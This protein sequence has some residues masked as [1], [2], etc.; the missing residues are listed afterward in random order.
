MNFLRTAHPQ[1]NQVINEFEIEE[2]SFSKLHRLI[3]LVESIIKTHTAFIAS[4]Y[5]KMHL[6][7]DS[8]KGLLAEGLIT[9]SLGMWQ[10]VSRALMEDLIV[11]NRL[12]RWEFKIIESCLDENQCNI[13]NN[14]YE[15]INDSY[16]LKD[17]I[18]K[19]EKDQLLKY[20]GRTNYQM[21][22]PLFVSGFYAYFKEWDKKIKKTIKTKDGRELKDLV[23]FRNHYA[24][25]AT[26]SAEECERAI[27]DYLPIVSN[28]LQETWLQSISVLVFEKIDGRLQLVSFD[29]HSNNIQIELLQT[30]LSTNKLIK[31]DIP[32]FLNQE[33]HLLD[34]SPLLFYKR[35]EKDN[36][37][38]LLFLNDLKRMH[39]EEIS[40]LNYPNAFHFQDKERYKQF[41]SIINIPEWKKNSSHEFKKQIYS[42]TESFF[43][44]ETELKTVMNQIKIKAKPFLFIWGSQG[45]GKSAFMAKILKEMNSFMDSFQDN[46]AIFTFEYFLRKNTIYSDPSYFLDYLN[47]QLERVRNTKIKVIGNTLDEKKELLHQRLIKISNSL[48]EQSIVILIDGV[49]EGLNN[50]ILEFLPTHEYPGILFIYSSRKVNKVEKFYNS[51]SPEKKY[52]SITLENLS[53]QE[54]QAILYRVVNKYE[55]IQ[56]KEAMEIILA[57]SQ[58][59]PLFLKLLLE[60]FAT[61]EI[62]LD[63]IEQVPL[64]L[65]GLFE[66]FFE[67]F[68]TEELGNAIIQTLLIF[69]EAKDYLSA[70][71]IEI[72][73]QNAGFSVGT[74]D[75]EY[76]LS[77]L[78]EVLMESP[79]TFYT[80][81][82]FHEEF[83]KFILERF[84]DEIKKT[85][86]LLIN[87]CAGWKGLSYFNGQL[88]NYALQFFVDHAVE[89]KDSEKLLGLVRDDEYRQAQITETKQYNYTFYMLKKCHE[90]VNQQRLT[91]GYLNNIEQKLL[92]EVLIQSYNLHQKIRSDSQINRAISMNWNIES[93]NEQLEKIKLLSPREQSVSSLFIINSLTKKQSNNG[94]VLIKKILSEIEEENLKINLTEDIPNEVII[95]LCLRLQKMNIDFS[96]LLKRCNIPALLSKKYLKVIYKN[97]GLEKFALK[98][99]EQPVMEMF[100]LGVIN[101]L[102]EVLIE[103]KEDERAK[104][105]FDMFQDQFNQNELSNFYH[106]LAIR[107]L[108]AGDKVRTE[109]LLEKIV[110]NSS[111]LLLFSRKFHENGWYE[112]ATKL[113]DNAI[114]FIKKAE[115]EYSVS[116]D[117]ASDLYQSYSSLINYF[118]FLN[119]PNI[120]EYYLPFYKKMLTLPI[121]SSNPLEFELANLYLQHQWYSKL[122]ELLNYTLSRKKVVHDELIR[123]IYVKEKNLPLSLKQE[124]ERKIIKQISRIKDI[125]GEC[126]LWTY[127][128]ENMIIEKSPLVQKLLSKFSNLST[129][130]A[131][132]RL[133]SSAV[134]GYLISGENT[135][136]FHMIKQ[137]PLLKEPIEVAIATLVKSKNDKGFEELLSN[138]SNDNIKEYAVTE[139]VREGLKHSSLTW[140][141]KYLPLVKSIES[142][143]ELIKSAAAI[144]CRKGDTDKAIILLLDSLSVGYNEWIDQSKQ[145][146][147]LALAERQIIEGDLG[148]HIFYNPAD[149]SPLWRGHF[150]LT[151]ASLQIGNYEKSLQEVS[152]IDEEDLLYEGYELDRDKKSKLIKQIIISMAKTGNEGVLKVLNEQY[153]KINHEPEHK[154]DPFIECAG[155][156]RRQ[157]K[158]EIEKKI[159]MSAKKYI[160]DLENKQP[161][162]PYYCQLSYYYYQI[163]QLKEAEKLLRLAWGELIEQDRNKYAVNIFH[164][165]SVQGLLD[166]W[167]KNQKIKLIYEKNRRRINSYLI[168]QQLA[169]GEFNTVKTLIANVT[170]SYFK[171]DYYLEL[172]R[173]LINLNNFNE[174]LTTYYLIEDEYEQKATAALLIL[175]Y[176]MTVETVTEPREIVKIIQSVDSDFHYEIEEQ[177]VYTLN[178]NNYKMVISLLDTLELEYREKQSLIHSI[179]PRM[180]KIA[181]E[182]REFNPLLCNIDLNQKSIFLALESLSFYLSIF[183]DQNKG[184]M[185]RLMSKLGFRK[186]QKQNIIYKDFSGIIEK[187]L[188][189]YKNGYLTN[190]EF[191]SKI[192]ELI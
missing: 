169:N 80:F 67:R 17:T 21:N 134:K 107:F 5:F 66:S 157:Q 133:Y 69:T 180:I 13:I 77:A 6:V 22:E 29:D 61:G 10:T 103:N 136:A 164:Q 92:Y 192:N 47:K 122:N 162:I 11:K 148:G 142:R 121:C 112:E 111:Q 99:L 153:V 127:F 138:L 175:E 83:R 81:Q 3:D 8:V 35:R 187:W 4:N 158:Y 100:K 190:E 28:I 116:S 38:M 132:K 91:K 53:N 74:K 86:Q 7:S 31:T 40:L 152:L 78:K 119:K 191:K 63:T 120:T 71:Q 20:F 44:R 185:N 46:K 87:Y 65:R 51:I 106:K 23:N 184:L 72:I 171:A 55:L 135:T 160:R 73:L 101:G 95:D 176:V 181:Q 2:H 150:Q 9:P 186:D 68:S 102:L 154:L 110:L 25:G 131:K 26:A 137:N 37:P 33:G 188:E 84:P 144:Y 124:M 16:I 14:L 49:D 182:F 59:N 128:I 1:L 177:F 105:W 125:D 98:L 88:I 24:H 62:T 32:Y 52:S 115:I 118:I 145:S 114:E 174:A 141:E 36:T 41:L 34:A 159:L 155:L 79:N 166:V 163:G 129:T 97:Q 178:S 165:L 82:L 151:Q 76:I 70:K 170:D 130:Y 168:N 90:Y 45:I 60:S 42:L 146:L 147:N 75:S 43:G 15:N 93:L 139:V 27:N 143:N 64:N 39:K 19:K 167:I 161:K 89:Q 156:F 30:I 126:E 123:Y 85:R 183:P 117:Y 54:V 50:N 58:G 96:V 94:Y 48:E 173:F 12:S 172:I 189:E 179:L 18:S 57:R 109:E 56:N 149:F 113:F 108:E 140:F 104:K